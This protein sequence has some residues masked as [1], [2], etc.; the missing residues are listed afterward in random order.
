MC[1]F[2]AIFQA[3]PEFP[4]FVV[5][6]RDESRSR[7]TA[8]PQLHASGNGARWVGG[9]DLIAGGTWLG[10]NEAGLLIAVTNRAKS[11]VAASVQSRGLLCRE[12]LR[13]ASFN[14]ARLEFDR[15]WNVHE[16][17][18]FNLLIF[19]REQAI[20]V[21]AGDEY[22]VTPLKPGIHIIANQGLN[23]LAD[24]RV[25][26]ARREVEA[27]YAAS[28][29]IDKWIHESKRIAALPTQAD[30]PGLCLHRTKEWG[31]VSSTILALAAKPERSR[32]HYA[33]GPPCEATYTDET[34]LLNS[35]LTPSAP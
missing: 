28:R 22:R 8:P 16:F 17:A 3:Q 30:Q 7:P 6:N 29:D 35:I 15:Q 20:V 13:Q 31:T 25:A 5:A 9:S 12:L 24:P 21:E 19:S 27:M 1:I 26:R 33:A 4:L 2:A 10:M 32:Y 23:D 11:H 18:G 34:P 14:A